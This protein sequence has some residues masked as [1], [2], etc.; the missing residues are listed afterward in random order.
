MAVACGGAPVEGQSTPP[1]W[2]PLFNGH[3]LEGWVP[4]I[5]GQPLGH[6]PLQT[7]RVVDGRLTVS[8]DGYSTFDDRFGHLFHE[9]SR[10]DYD[11][12]LEYR[13]VG[14][15]MPDG[16]GWARRNS[17]VMVHAQRPETMGVDQDFPISVEVQLLGADGDE[18]RPTAN[19]CTPGTHVRIAGA[20]TEQHCIES[21]SASYSGDEWVSIELHVRGGDLIRHV[22]EGDTV[23]VYSDPVVGGGVVSGFVASAKVDGTPLRSG[24]IALQSESHPIQFRNVVIREVASR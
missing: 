17:G 4:K 11:L 5:R 8:Y 2:V 10:A 24:W 15:Q 7:F 13:F 23:L 1:S 22:V 18:R 14:D 3:D 19:L 12:R 21:S 20:R 9:V 16:P 6:D